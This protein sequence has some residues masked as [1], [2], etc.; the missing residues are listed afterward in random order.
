MPKSKIKPQGKS[1]CD[2]WLEV[3]RDSEAEIAAASAR[4]RRLRR[5]IVGARAQFDAA[6]PFPEVDPTLDEE[7]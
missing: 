2:G 7:P 5:V 3:I 6:V 4:I 1:E